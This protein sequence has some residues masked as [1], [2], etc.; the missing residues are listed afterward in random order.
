MTLTTGTAGPLLTPEQVEDLLI[1]PVLTASVA[2][3]PLCS[4]VLRPTASSVRLP[5]VTADPTAAWVA[6]GA[7]IPISD[8]T[9]AE[10]DVVTRKV[11]GLSVVTSE[12][13]EDSNPEATAEVG[14]GLARDIARKV[15]AAFFGDGTAQSGEQPDG[16]AS[17]TVGAGG[18]QDIAAGT[19]PTDLDAFAEAQMLAANVGAQ[20]T[21]FVTNPVT[22]LVLAN[23]KEATGSGKP[24]LQPDPTQPTR[25]MIFGVPLLTSP[26]APVGT[27][28]GLPAERVVTAVRRDSEVKAD[29]SVFF[30]SDRVAVRATCR[31]GFGFPH[32]A[33][34]VRIRLAA[35]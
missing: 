14:R 8:L 1:K 7:E 21:A 32:T 22:A 34:L 13:A 29:R 27:V 26:E 15:D 5:A 24:L 10:I 6:E 31:V 23:L 18:V 11:A 35:S 3:N 2:L 17:L 16:L 33:A 9:T 4:R 20:L 25:R 12:L 19:A 28:W 30:T